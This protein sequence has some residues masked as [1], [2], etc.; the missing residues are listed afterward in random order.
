MSDPTPKPVPA[1]DPSERDPLAIAREVLDR[2]AAALAAVRDRL[3][4]TFVRAVTLLEAVAGRIIVTGVGKSGLIGSKIAA[5]LTSVGSPAFFLHPTEALHG[6]LG[7]VGPHD[8][9]IAI[10]KSGRS[11]ELLQLVPYFKRVGMGLIAVVETADSPLGHEADVVIELGRIE[12]ACS[13]DL[14][15]TSSTTATLAVGDALA[16]ALLRRRGLTAEDLAFVHPGGLI[17]R[18]AARRVG[19]AMKGGKTLPVLSETATLREALLEIVDKGLGMTCLVDASGDLSGVLTD[20][21]LKRILLG[22]GGDHPLHG[23]VTRF[24][25][26]NPRT[27]GAEALVATAVR[28]M[29]APRPGPVTSLVVVNGTK[30]IG[31]VHLHDCLRTDAVAPPPPASP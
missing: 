4:P 23:E 21:D 3:G 8:V 31:I 25:T 12:E 20:G 10:S 30:P 5:T 9:G 28:E 19:D 22:P 14:V 15:P 26:R 11:T 16:V 6:D 1:G 13:L 18:Q 29:E 7:I 27:I 24:M 2:E 17:G